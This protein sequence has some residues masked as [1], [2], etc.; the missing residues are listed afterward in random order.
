M[1]HYLLSE[2]MTLLIN[3]CDLY[4]WPTL[5]FVLYY[6]VSLLHFFIFWGERSLYLQPFSRYCTLSVLGS[7]VW[8][9]GITWRPLIGHATIW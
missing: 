3:V 4:V 1:P 6:D 5:S 9:F 7:R 2:A 8:P